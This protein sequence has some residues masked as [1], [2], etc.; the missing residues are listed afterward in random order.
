[1]L[2]VAPCLFVWVWVAVPFPAHDATPNNDETGSLVSRRRDE[3]GGRV[4]KGGSS[5]DGGGY[6]R[7]IIEPN[8]AFFLF[9]YYGQSFSIILL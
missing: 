5:D 7:K 2:V 1:M 3:G 8:F 9:Y 4:D 6:G